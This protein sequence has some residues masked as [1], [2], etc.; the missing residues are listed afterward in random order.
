MRLSPKQVIFLAVT[1]Y[2]NEEESYKLLNELANTNKMNDNTFLKIV[3]KYFDFTRLYKEAK[4]PEDA[5]LFNYLVF[6][7]YPAKNIDPENRKQQISIRGKLPRR[8]GIVQYENKITIPQLKLMETV[9]KQL[10][11]LD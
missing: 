6:Q 3:G 2:I 1:N 8:G 10:N 11:R 4:V 5:I 7:T 9:Y